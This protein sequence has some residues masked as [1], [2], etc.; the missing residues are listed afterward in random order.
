MWLCSC[1]ST[2]KVLPTALDLG[3]ALGLLMPCQRFSD[4]RAKN[5]PLH[6]TSST[7]T[8]P[9]AGPRLWIGWNFRRTTTRLERTTKSLN[10]WS[11]YIL[12]GYTIVTMKNEDMVPLLLHEPPSSSPKL[13]DPQQTDIS[14]I[15]FNYDD[16][17][18]MSLCASNPQALWRQKIR[19]LVT[20]Q[21]DYRCPVRAPQLCCWH[22]LQLNLTL[23]KH[24]FDYSRGPILVTTLWPVDESFSPV[25]IVHTKDGRWTVVD[26]CQVQ[27]G[28]GRNNLKLLVCLKDSNNQAVHWDMGHV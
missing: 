18:F 27:V 13:P 3:T 12:V 7:T 14:L 10:H 6:V 16:Q 24:G 28:N 25:H 17:T 21:S 26:S 22:D 15:Y 2:S 23:Q 19:G 11:T 5:T 4:H 1:C 8:V 20:G 9:F